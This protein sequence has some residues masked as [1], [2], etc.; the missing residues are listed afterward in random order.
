MTDRIRKLAIVGAS[1]RAA[2]FSALRGGFEPTTADMFADADLERV[3]SAVRE[4]DYPEGLAAWL[5]A[6][7]CDGWLYS[8]ALENHPAL[9]DRMAAIRPLAG[10]CGAALRGARD[11]LALQQK[12]AAA[13]LAFPETRASAAGLPQDGSWLCK[14]GR[15]ASGAGVWKLDGPA[16]LVRAAEQGALFQRCVGGESTAAIF[17]LGERST[18]L[19]G[20]TLQWV[21]PA[22][23]RQAPWRYVGS[24]GPWH[25]SSPIGEQLRRLEKLLA[26]EMG[27]RGL[28]GVDLILDDERAWVVEVNPRLTASVEVVERAVGTSLVAAHVAACTD[29]QWD[30]PKCSVLTDYRDIARRFAKA[31]YYA[32][33]DA[34]TTEKFCQWALNQSSLDPSHCRLADLP[35]AGESIPQ[36]RPVL[37]VLADGPGMAAVEGI[38]QRLAE[39][40]GRLYAER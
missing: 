8:G 28:V 10:N 1:A 27:L 25:A 32:P 7:P 9:I 26:R 4:Q 39:V 19:A 17:V 13:G 14:T 30:A 24:L 34:T 38:R 35:H 22:W 2:A 33:R 21:G 18:W 37:T 3:C 11:V 36:G 6:T 16:A 31:I 40:E 23:G 29:P 12:L 20:L 15:G 5:A